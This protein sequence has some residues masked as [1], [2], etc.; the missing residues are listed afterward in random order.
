[1]VDFGE[2]L[3]LADDLTDTMSVVSG[4][5]LVAESDYRRLR[6]PSGALIDDP[7]YGYDLM[8]LLSKAMTQAERATIPGHIV[9]ELMKDDRHENVTATVEDDGQDK[10][11]VSVLAELGDG[12]SFSLVMGVAEAGITL[13]A[14]EQVQ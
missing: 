3:S 14:L 11:K 8:S 2:D 13:L 5:M 7:D 12:T 10:L 4:T 6:T 1:M 9:T